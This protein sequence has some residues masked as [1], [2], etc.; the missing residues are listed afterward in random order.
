[1]LKRYEQKQVHDLLEAGLSVADV[2]KRTGRSLGTIYK[3]K[4]LDGYKTHS[5][6]KDEEQQPKELIPYLEQIDKGIKRKS[7]ARDIFFDMQRD[8][9]NDSRLIFEAY[10]RE[11]KQ[12]LNPQRSIQHRETGPGEEAQVDWGHFGELTINGKVEKVYLFAYILSYS[13]AIYLEFVVR[14]NQKTLQA[15][16]MNAFEQLGIPKTILYDNMKTVVSRREKLADG[17]KKVHYNLAFTEFARYYQFVPEACHPYWPRHKGKVENTIKFVRNYFSRYTPKAKFTLEELN[18]QLAD[19]V[20][21]KAHQREH[22]TTHA[23]PYDLWI[24]ERPFLSSPANLPPYNSSPVLYPRATQH[25][26]ITHKGITYNLGNQY[27][28]KK[29][30]IR[31]I[32]EHGLPLIEF[33]YAD[34]LLKIVPVPA[35]KHSWVTVFDDEITSKPAV[36]TAAKRQEQTQPIP[37]VLVK[38]RDVSYYS[39][40]P[41]VQ[42]EVS[43]G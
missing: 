22:R 27:A 31:E 35:K 43:Y 32:Q 37:D 4:Q 24:K 41:I 13:R 29:L 15:C 38:Q 7:K 3:Y 5:T 34:T 2:A 10:Y 12:E 1:M 28:R 6:K 42:G 20:R 14:Q 16:H 8:G 36:L 26:L 23:K 11:R 30:E 9:F 18:E 25:G 40:Q 33:Y 17:T 39:I 19:W 21:D